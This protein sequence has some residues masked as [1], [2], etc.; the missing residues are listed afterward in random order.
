MKYKFSCYDCKWHTDKCKNYNSDQYNKF[1][2]FIN[3]CNIKGKVDNSLG[4][5]WSKL[6]DDSI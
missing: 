6:K 1:P 5:S 3:E 2:D 4:G